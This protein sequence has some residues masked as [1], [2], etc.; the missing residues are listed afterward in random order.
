[1]TV[2][3]EEQSSKRMEYPT[4]CPTLHPTSWATLAATLMAATR[5]GCVH[6][7]LPALL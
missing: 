1:M 7:I 3:S 2:L 5:L 6:P 4:S